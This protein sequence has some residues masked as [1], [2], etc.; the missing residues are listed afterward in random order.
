MIVCIV[1]LA[2][3]EL[4]RAYI[5]GSNRLQGA[6]GRGAEIHMAQITETGSRNQ[7]NNIKIINGMKK[8]LHALVAVSV[9]VLLLVSCDKEPEFIP[10]IVLSQTEFDLPDD[11]T[12]IEVEVKANVEFGVIFSGKWITRNTTKDLSST[13]LFFNIAKNESYDK[14]EDYILIKQEKGELTIPIHVVQSQKDAII[15]SNKNVE[16]SR[17]S[18]ILEVV[19]RTNIE[20]DVI[21]PDIAQ[22]WVSL[23]GTKALRDKTLMLNIAENTS[24]EARM[25]EV[26]VK[27]KTTS[28][29]D[30]LNIT[31][32]CISS[33]FI[34]V[35]KMG[36]LGTILNQTQKDT[37]TRMTLKG[38]I[39][40]ADFEVMKLQIP[41]LLY[42]DLE[43]VKCEG[44]KIPRYAI[45][46]GCKVK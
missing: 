24:K 20:I 30:T 1:V 31:Q 16:L 19:L 28:L 26:Y 5:P 15:I 18:R 29:Q 23:A 17:E 41:N 10:E 9:L 43:E 38:E 8:V 34:R 11:A 25:T 2:F 3:Q 4:K 12:V 14:R 6:R 21:I 35:N 27:N 33:N 13:K 40:A 42:L 32:H 39:N 22:S 45:G 46:G 37:I 36:T 7:S 44:D